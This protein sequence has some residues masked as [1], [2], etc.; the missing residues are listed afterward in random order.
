VRLDGLWKVERRSGVL[1]PLAGMRKRIDGPRGET[2]LGPLRVPFDVL[3]DELHYRRPLNGFV[4]LLHVVDGDHVRGRATFRGHEYGQFDL[5][6]IKE[7]GIT[8]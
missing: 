5:Q 7:R 2:L 1:P 3:G 8:V 6:R 4:D